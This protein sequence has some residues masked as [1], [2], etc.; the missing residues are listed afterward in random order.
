VPV[1]LARLPDERLPEAVE[2]AAYF[3]VAEGLTNVAKYA[4][5]SHATV[6]IERENGRLVVEVSDDGIGGADPEEGTGLR[7]LADRIAV[8]EGRLEIASERGRGTTIR[9]QIPCA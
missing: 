8:L 2:L 6:G 9:A 3:V 4:S 5:A 1:E 7:G